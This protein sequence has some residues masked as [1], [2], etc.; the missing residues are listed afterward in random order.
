MSVG[1]VAG[2][3]LGG[4]LAGAFGTTTALLVDAATFVVLAAACFSLHTRRAPLAGAA[5]ATDREERRA[6]FR[7][8]WDD[9]VLRVVLAVSAIATACAVLDNVAAPFR[10][11]DQLGT[12]ATGYG[13]YLTIWGAGMMAGAQLPPRIGRQR[14]RYVAAVGELLCSL[15]IAGIG[16]APG[17]PLAYV[18]SAIGGVGNGMAN[19]AQN[20]LVG[21]RVPEATRGR[22]FAAS[23]AVMQTATVLGTAAGGPVVAVLGA[24]R[25]MFV[26]G[27]VGAG[28]C[29][30]GLGALRGA[31]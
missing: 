13:V 2:P 1:F 6:G 14:E 15:G 10:F 22:A 5:L 16:V 3:A 27:L 7:T 28:A 26:C 30:A 12:T 11:L 9:R 23:G 29:V 17:L 19:V 18:A 31:R 20:A 21:T 4:I 8:L 24:G 25:A